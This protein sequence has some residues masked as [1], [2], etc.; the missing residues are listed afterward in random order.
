[1]A[2][3]A[4]LLRL[5]GNWKSSQWQ[6]LAGPVL[7]LLILS[8]MVLPLP[9]FLLDLLFTFNIALSIMVLLVAMFTK[10]TLDFAAF[11][12]IFAVYHVVTF[13]IK[14]GFNAYHLNGRAY[15]ARSRRARC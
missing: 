13:I 1:M 12:T 15:R 4:S 8:M 14:R 11:P 5:P 7:I 2:N 10:R 6:I 3:L 9:P